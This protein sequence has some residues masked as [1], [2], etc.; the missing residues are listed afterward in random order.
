MYAGVPM[1]VPGSVSKA[2]RAELD[3]E[4]DPTLAPE[5]APTLETVS[6]M[7]RRQLLNFFRG[8]YRPENMVIAAAGNLKHARL[9]RLVRRGFGGLER[10][11]RRVAHVL[12][13]RRRAKARRVSLESN[14]PDRLQRLPF[15]TEVDVL[16][17]GPCHRVHLE[18]D[19]K[20]PTPILVL[21]ALTGKGPRR[22]RRRLVV[23]VHQPVSG[24][25]NQHRMMKRS[26][27][28]HGTRPSPLEK[29]HLLGRSRAAGDRRPDPCGDGLWLQ[30]PR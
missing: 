13:R 15:L 12:C 2:L 16:P 30:A 25:P 21:G 11:A 8:A 5:R 23:D 9:A 22:K 17:L 29:A 28:I 7:S 3:P 10:G 26:R 4:L 19:V 27:S 24:H 18:V 14:H 1:T 6:S 20:D